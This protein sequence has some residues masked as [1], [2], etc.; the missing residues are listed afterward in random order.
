VLA[1]SSCTSQ[2]AALQTA[3]ALGCKTTQERVDQL[4]QSSC[5]SAAAGPITMNGMTTDASM[6]EQNSN[7]T[8]DISVPIAMPNGDVAA[9]LVCHINTRH[10]SVV[11]ARLTKGPTTKEEAEYLRSLGACEE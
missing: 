8:S 2:G 5:A 11:Y 10:G 7:A 4:A 3:A 1:I 6:R 9:E